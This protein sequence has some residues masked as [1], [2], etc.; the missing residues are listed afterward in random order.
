MVRSWI[1][2]KEIIL[3][4]WHDTSANLSENIIRKSVQ[5]H[6]ISEKMFSNLVAELVLKVIIF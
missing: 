4:E 5:D 2:T 3:S 6:R 1:D